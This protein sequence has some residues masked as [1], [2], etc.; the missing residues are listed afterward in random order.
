MKENLPTYRSSL[1]KDDPW[2]TSQITVEQALPIRHQVLWPNKTIEE[3]RVEDDEIGHHFGVYIG[4]D[5]VCV[6]SIFIDGKTARLRKFATLEA[7]Q[8]KGIGS[9]VL[10]HIVRFLKQHSVQVFWCD[11]RESAMSLYGRFGMQSQGE[12]FYK[13]DVPYRKMQVAL[14]D[15]PS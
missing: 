2:T 1:E 4:Q 12:R 3:C 5:L 10:H 8:G 6:A 13:G 11:A 7:Y 15:L 14:S 9:A